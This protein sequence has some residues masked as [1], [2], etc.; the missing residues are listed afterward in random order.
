MS[1]ANLVN[2][3]GKTEKLIEKIFMKLLFSSDII[4]STWFFY[5]KML[6]RFKLNRFS[7]LRK[8][9]I[10]GNVPEIR[11]TKIYNLCIVRREV[12]YEYQNLWSIV[13]RTPYRVYL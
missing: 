5:R 2:Y 8:E 11:T 3:A 1:I 12:V 10:V 4:F 13:G 6:Y 9:I 7:S